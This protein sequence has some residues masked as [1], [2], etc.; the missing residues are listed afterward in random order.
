MTTSFSWRFVNA[1]YD[2]PMGSWRRINLE[3]APF[4]LPPPMRILIEGC[5][6]TDGL[7]ADKTISV[8]PVSQI[9]RHLQERFPELKLKERVST[10]TGIWK[11]AKLIDDL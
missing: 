3:L 11:M 8:W 2:I 9:K 1:N 7:L 5:T 6:E 10:I 4:F